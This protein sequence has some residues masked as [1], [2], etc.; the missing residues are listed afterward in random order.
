[1]MRVLVCGRRDYAGDGLRV[2]LTELH[3]G[4]RGPITE[5]IEG[6]AKGADRIGAAWADNWSVPR[7]RF[8]ADWERHGRSAGPKRNQRMIDEG[9]PDLVIAAPGGRGTADMVRRARAAG[10]EVLDVPGDLTILSETE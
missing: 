6:G 7:R 1:M 9:R 3:G 4:P 2:A 10:I 5:M 8:D